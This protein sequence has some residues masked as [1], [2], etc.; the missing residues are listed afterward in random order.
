V[1]RRFAAWGLAALTL[2]AA[3][4]AGAYW[5]W[6]KPRA[7]LEERQRRQEALR[8]IAA[9][10]FVRARV[11]SGYVLVTGGRCGPFDPG[12]QS[13]E[14]CLEKGSR[15]GEVLQYAFERYAYDSRDSVACRIRP[16]TAN[17]WECLPR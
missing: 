16:K 4:A 9:H 11:D 15:E 3:S 10:D 13:V 17:G 5:L 8:E 6:L 1:R 2:A 12:A 7:I 14:F